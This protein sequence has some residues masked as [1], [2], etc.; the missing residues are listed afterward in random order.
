MTPLIFAG[1]QIRQ[2][3][4]FIKSLYATDENSIINLVFNY[5]DI[6]NEL[7]NGTSRKSVVVK[8]R[9]IAMYFLRKKTILSTTKIGDLF[10]RDHST[11]IASTQ[12][13]DDLMDTDPSYK[14]DMDRLAEMI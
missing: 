14:F 1:L 10:N 13:V 8:P 6:D 11:V 4:T 3:K 2:Q 9:Q 7:A 5:F 12:K